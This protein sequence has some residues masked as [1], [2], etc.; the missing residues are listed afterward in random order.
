MGAPNVVVTPTRAVQLF[1]T[2]HGPII[3]S[4]LGAIVAYLDDLSTV[5]QDSYDISLHPGERISWKDDIPCWAIA[6]SVG[7]TILNLSKS[8]RIPDPE[9]DT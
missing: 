8:V 4:N 9:E 3:I 1:T 5:S 7:T 6:N 2:A